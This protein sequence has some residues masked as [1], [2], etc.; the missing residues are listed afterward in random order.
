MGSCVVNYAFRS[1]LDQEFHQLQSFV[2]LPPFFGGLFSKALVY[3]G[4]DLV[5]ELAVVALRKRG[6]LVRWRTAWTG[7]TD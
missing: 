7:M 5:E 1:V 4:H 2:D 6:T 3:H